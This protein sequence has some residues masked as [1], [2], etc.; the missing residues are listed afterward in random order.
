[1]SCISPVSLTA[2]INF[3][4]FHQSVTE[5]YH[6]SL[7]YFILHRYTHL[8][9]S[10]SF[11]YQTK[12]SD[13]NPEPNSETTNFLFSCTFKMSSKSCKCNKDSRGTNITFCSK[14]VSSEKNNYFKNMNRY[15]SLPTKHK[16]SIF[17]V[18][19]HYYTCSL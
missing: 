16:M 8:I 10:I 13:F 19:V 2:S 12:H 3:F 6:L 4:P 9:S 5:R 1:M 18:I 15:T 11:S 14:K 7:P 17:R